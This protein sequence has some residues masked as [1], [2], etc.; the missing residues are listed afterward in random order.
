MGRFRPKAFAHGLGPV[1]K[2]GAQEVVVAGGDGSGAPV[3]GDC[4][5]GVLQQGR[6]TGDLR[7]TE[8]RR[9]RGSEAR[10]TEEEGGGATCNTHFCE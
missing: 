2:D 4:G 6:S 10:L 3:A 7:R 5:G 8:R 9:K 1:A